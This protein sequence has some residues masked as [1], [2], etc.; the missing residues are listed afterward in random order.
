MRISPVIVLTISGIVAG[1]RPPDLHSR[2]GGRIRTHLALKGNAGTIPC[3][4]TALT[5]VT[6]D[7]LTYSINEIA[8]ARL[9]QTRRRSDPNSWKERFFPRPG[10]PRGTLNAPPAKKDSPRH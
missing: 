6:E 7:G 2:H 10:Q 3:D 9:V 5:F 4:G 8:E 1:S